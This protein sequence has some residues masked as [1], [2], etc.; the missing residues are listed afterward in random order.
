MFLKT[1]K[2]V[3]W[4]A[5]GCTKHPK[6]GQNSTTTVRSVV[7][8]KHFSREDEIFLALYQKLGNQMVKEINV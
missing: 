5:F 2:K 8:K 4:P 7:K 3:F 6:A 1:A